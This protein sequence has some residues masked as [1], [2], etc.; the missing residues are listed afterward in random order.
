M[1]IVRIEYIDDEQLALVTCSEDCPLSVWGQVKRIF[2]ERGHGVIFVS[3]R[4]IALPWWSFLS[5][6]EGVA[7]IL[8]RNGLILEVSPEAKQLL[9]LA[10]AREEAF[11]EATRQNEAKS[12]E[13][14]EEELIKRGF[15][16]R[17]KPYQ[18]R[19]VAR[20]VS[21]PAGATFSVPGAGKTTEALAFFF[22]TS[23]ERDRLLVVS[24]KNAFA[25]WEDELEECVPE[26]TFKFNR[27][28]GGNERISTVLESDPKGAIITYHQ[29]ARSVDLIGKYL[30]RNATYMCLDESHRMKRGVEGVHGSSIL[31]LCHL[32]KRKLI[33][34]GTPLPNSVSDLIPQFNY[35][36]PEVVVD[37]KTAVDNLRNIYVRTTKHELDLGPVRR[38]LHPVDLTENQRRL[39]DALCSDTARRLEGLSVRDRIRFRAFSKS[40]Q[41]LLQAVSNPSLLMNS[42]IRANSLLTEVLKE[43]ISSKL[44]EA[45][46]IAR[47]LAEQ[48]SK[49]LIWS[50]FVNTVEQMAALLQDLN[51]VYI[52]GGVETSED[53]E[54]SDTREAKLKQFHD[55]SECLALVANPAACA[56]GISLHRVCHFSI[57]IDRNY[58][59]AQYLQSEDR[60]HR[61]GLPNNIQTNII[62][63]HS[64]E[65][66]DESVNRRLIAKVDKMQAIL[67]DPDL[68]I[69]P[70]DLDDFGSGI[71]QDDIEDLKK[72]LLRKE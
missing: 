5:F 64:P 46:R 22:L 50:F 8:R 36:Y 53:D 31:Q 6:R 56:E 10:L 24:P 38:V 14:L 25:V 66:I 21:L 30:A 26:A 41:H 3:P 49:V 23:E 18:L 71:N 4:A 67:D 33:M 59:A 34:T 7:Y 52:H 65:T 32:P 51:A 47:E 40:V 20:L 69:R 54:L 1:P 45:C 27:L 37:E 17:L 60:I 2:D 35:L 58:N 72:M 9:Q 55:D 63:L 13:E 61:I 57:Y 12:E 11:S 44:D 68:D 19:N 70:I 62:I 48:G 28:T 29:L 15:L 43:G 16:R 42:E 39:Y